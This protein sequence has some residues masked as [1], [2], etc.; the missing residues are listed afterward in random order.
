MLDGLASLVRGVT[1]A[2]GAI[3]DPD[4]ASVGQ[5]SP[6]LPQEFKP[7]VPATNKSLFGYAFDYRTSPAA[8][9]LIH[10]HSGHVSDTADANGLHGWVDDG[11]TP[12]ERFAMD[13]NASV[14]EMVESMR[15]EGE[16]NGIAVE[17]RFAEGPLTIDGDRF[18]LGRVFR[19]LISNAIQATEAGGRI[20]IVTSRAGEKV[21]IT[22]ADTGSGIPADRLPKIFDDFVTTKRRGLGLGLA[23][24]RELARDLAMI[25]M[26]R[27]ELEEVVAK[28]RPESSAKAKH[29]AHAVSRRTA[30]VRD[31]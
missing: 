22:V 2:I 14:A 11:I 23:I 12:I 5:N 17:A 4:S 31:E 20:A 27:E 16:R 3:K 6:L 18:A 26:R 10:I 25:R 24:G 19:N 7:N 21:Q 13:V 15:P 29:R 1:G 28:W 8:F 9:G 30:R